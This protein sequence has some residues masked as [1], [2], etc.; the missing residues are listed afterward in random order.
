MFGRR[1]GRSFPR[2]GHSPAVFFRGAP[3]GGVCSSAAWKTLSHEL[4]VGVSLSSG[5]VCPGRRAGGGAGDGNLSPA[6]GGGVEGVRP[7]SCPVAPGSVAARDE[8]LFVPPSARF[9]EGS[10][11][12]GAWGNLFHR[13]TKSEVPSSPDGEL[14]HLAGSPRGALAGTTFSPASVSLTG[15]VPRGKGRER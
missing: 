8:S 2:G 4:V 12:H 6:P 11:I 7:A 15:E 10:G 1:G 3:G 14:A 13:N 9:L 5:A